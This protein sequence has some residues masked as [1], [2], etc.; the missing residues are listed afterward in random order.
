MGL[1]EE[2]EVSIDDCVLKIIKGDVVAME[3]S[4]KSWTRGRR[5]ETLL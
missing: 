4:L 1:Y 3:R 2:G 5:Y